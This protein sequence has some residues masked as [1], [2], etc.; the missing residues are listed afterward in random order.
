MPPQPA[1]M[2]KAEGKLPQG[3]Q[4]KEGLLCISRLQEELS[5]VSEPEWLQV[6]PSRGSQAEVGPRLQQFEEMLPGAL[7]LQQ[8]EEEEQPD[9]LQHSNNLRGRV[10]W[11]GPRSNNRQKGNLQHSDCPRVIGLQ[12]MCL[13]LKRALA[14]TVQG[15]LL[16]KGTRRVT[17]PFWAPD[18]HVTKRRDV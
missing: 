16:R 17:E 3:L 9:V 2:S 15:Y 14:D 12:F 4:P 8:L 18:R 1:S 10:C 11:Q 6:G 13:P 5:S 7:Q